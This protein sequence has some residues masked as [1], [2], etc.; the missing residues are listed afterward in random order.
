MSGRRVKK[1]SV[2]VLKWKLHERTVVFSSTFTSK[3]INCYPIVRSLDPYQTYNA[4]SHLV[5]FSQETAF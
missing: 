5:L 1:M 2:E 3:G 4:N